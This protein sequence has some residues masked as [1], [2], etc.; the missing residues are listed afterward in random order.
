MIRASFQADIAE[1]S[2]GE[3]VVAGLLHNHNSLPSSHE[4]VPVTSLGAKKHVDKYNKVCYDAARY[5]IH[6]KDD[7][8]IAKRAASRE[9]CGSS[10]GSLLQQCGI[11][12]L[13]LQT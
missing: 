7:E 13:R 12:D 5:F 11:N 3:G 10:I 2:S 8:I 9:Q 1:L 6:F 4:N